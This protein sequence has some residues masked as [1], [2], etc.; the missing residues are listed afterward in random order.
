MKMAPLSAMIGK[1]VI[2]KWTIDHTKVFTDVQH[3]V[4]QDKMLMHPNLTQ[5]FDLYTDASK[6]QIVYVVSQEGKPVG[7]EQELLGI[8]QSLKHFKYVI[9]V[10][11][12]IADTL[13]R[14]PI[15]KSMVNNKSILQPCLFKDTCIPFRFTKNKG[16]LVER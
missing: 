9:G 2:F 1:G 5:P 4:S 6:W 15:Q 10:N 11:N 14:L 12:L 13:C 7:Y 3:T 8:I 16:F